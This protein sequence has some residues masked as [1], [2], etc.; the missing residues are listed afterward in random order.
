[1]NVQWIQQ[2]EAELKQGTILLAGPLENPDPELLRT[3]RVVH[4]PPVSFDLL[5]ELGRA[6]EVLIMPYADLPVTRAMQ[7]LKLKEYLATGKPVVVS[8]LPAVESWSD[9]LDVVPTPQEFVRLV[10]ARSVGGIPADQRWAR[11]RLQ[12][13]S[14]QA[15]AEQFESWLLKPAAARQASENLQTM[16][17]CQPVSAGGI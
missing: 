1:M 11:Q 12:Q 7:P 16:A 15:I 4:L 5:P 2:L 6:A 17:S 14:W 9:C 13:E 10:K 3:P 8:D